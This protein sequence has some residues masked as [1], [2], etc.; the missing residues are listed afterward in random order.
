MEELQVGMC[1]KVLSVSEQGLMWFRPGVEKDAEEIG[2]WAR[3]CYMWPVL[4]RTCVQHKSLCS[5]VKVREV[6]EWSLGK[7]KDGAICG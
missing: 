1:T 2:A 7:D 5:L 4:G 3:D 6:V